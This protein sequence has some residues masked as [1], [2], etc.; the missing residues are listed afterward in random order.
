M[1]EHP[2]NV[3]AWIDKQETIY[4]WFSNKNLKNPKLEE[5]FSINIKMRARTSSAV[6]NN[7]SFFK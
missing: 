7:R 4:P 5:L 1:R 3:Q 6:W 2:L